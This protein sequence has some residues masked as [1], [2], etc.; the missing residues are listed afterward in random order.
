MASTSILS[1]YTSFTSYK[2]PCLE[3][4]NPN[5]TSTSISIH[6]HINI[7]SNVYKWV[8]PSDPKHDGQ[9]NVFEFD[10]TKMQI[11]FLID[12]LVGLLLMIS[13]IVFCIDAREQAMQDEYVV[14]S[15]AMPKIRF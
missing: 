5:S 8:I 2:K 11:V 4:N 3:T 12:G 15:T 10:D 7:P 9:N 6:P 14:R 1:L 13:T